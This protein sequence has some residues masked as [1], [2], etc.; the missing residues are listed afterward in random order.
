L[1]KIFYQVFFEGNAFVVILNLPSYDLL[2]YNLV[3]HN[4][5]KYNTV[6]PSLSRLFNTAENGS[7][8]SAPIR[9]QVSPGIRFFAGSMIAKNAGRLI[10][11]KVLVKNTPCP[12]AKLDPQ[13]Q[14]CR[15][16]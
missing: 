13:I 12:G 3:S 9:V 4:L 15:L 11:L 2:S 16:F 14:D 8:V 1:Q 6:H 10:T 5:P 7:P